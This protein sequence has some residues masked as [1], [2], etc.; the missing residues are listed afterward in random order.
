MHHYIKK[1]AH[2]CW[3]YPTSR[4]HVIFSVTRSASQT[5]T[6][7]L[8][9]SQFSARRCTA[10]I[11]SQNVHVKSSSFTVPLIFQAWTDTFSCHRQTDSGLLWEKQGPGTQ[12]GKELVSDRQT[13]HTKIGLNLLQLYFCKHLRYR[14]MI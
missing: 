5:P 8:V 10:S 13:P 9:S 1:M 2:V 14:H 3:F 11:Y 6:A 7:L 4:N 12:V